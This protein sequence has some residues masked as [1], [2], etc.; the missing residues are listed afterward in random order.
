MDD[1]YEQRRRSFGGVAE[2]YD[3]LRPSYPPELIDSVIQ[4]AGPALERGAL[5]VGAGTG[6]ATVLFAQ[7]GVRVHALEPDPD[8]A[9]VARRNCAQFPHVRIEVS[10]LE[11]WHAPRPF[12]LVFSAQAWHWVQRERGYAAARAALLPGE[13]LAAFWNW[14]QWEEVP[15]R[16]ELCEAYARA[17]PDFVDQAGPMHPASDSL[18]RLWGD[19]QGEIAASPAFADPQTE[20]YAWRRQYTAEEYL[21]LLLTHSDH[22]LLGERREELLEALRRVFARHGSRFEL[23]YLTRL[24]LA[25]AV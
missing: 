14:P 19:W 8:M 18:P 9:A 21:T 13:L 2:L 23:P 10:E 20:L 7:R 5:E 4:R 1:A 22:M 3:R 24:C 15:F 25:R 6:K 16:E 17:V 11:S 12:G